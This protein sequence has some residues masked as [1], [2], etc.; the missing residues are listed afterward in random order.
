MFSEVEEHVRC[1]LPTGEKSVEVVERWTEESG[2]IKNELRLG[3]TL[4]DD[5]EQWQSSGEWIVVV[6][7]NKR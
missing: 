3:I 6:D 5:D 1:S 4:A 2:S 7:T